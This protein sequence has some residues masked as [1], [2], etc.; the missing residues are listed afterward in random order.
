MIDV[1]LYANRNFS[2]S[3]FLLLNFIIGNMGVISLMP[4]LLEQFFN[5]PT[6][7]AGLVMAPFGV[8]SAM[9]MM[10]TGKLMTKID[11]R[12]FLTFGLVL[13]SGSSLLLS[14][15]DLSTDMP[16]W[17][18]AGII[19]GFGMGMFFVPLTTLAFRTLSPDKI[20]SLLDFSVFRGM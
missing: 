7:T 11:P 12:Y 8:A 17:V 13:T 18:V 16:H 9:A 3:C 19:Q 14:H 2:L 5:Y 20:R 1:Y 10:A 4:L 15:Y 6:K